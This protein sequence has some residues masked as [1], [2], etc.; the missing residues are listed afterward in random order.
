[1]IGLYILGLLV[2]FIVIIVVR[3]ILFRPK[4]QERVE[5]EKVKVNEDKIVEDMIALIQCKTVSYRDESLILHEEFTKFQEELKVRFPLVHEAC[6]LKKIGKNGLLYYL[7]GKSSDKVSVCMAH[8]DVVPADEEKWEKPP[9]S[10][11]LEDGV[12]W[13]RGTLDTKGTL[14]AVLEATEQLL[15]EGYKPENDVYFSFSGE[16]EIDGDTCA[17]IVSYFEEKGIRP[18]FVLDE[19]GAIVDNV[20]PGVE[21]D[22]ALIGVGEKGSVN[23]EFSMKSQGGH[24]STPPVHTI[25][26]KLAQAIVNIEKKPF[27]AQYTE[28]VLGMFDV[29]GR[30]SSFLYRLL[31]ANLWCFKPL[32]SLVCKISGGELNAL[33]RTTCA[34]TR[35]NGSDAFNVLP[36]EASFGLNMRVL[37]DETIESTKE[38]LQKIVGEEIDIQVI[39]GM[40]P[41]SYSDTNCEEYQMLTDVIFENWSDLIVS[42]YLMLA[43]SDSR[44][45]N[46]ISDHVYRFCAMKLSKEERGMIHGHNE[47]V[48]VET[49]LQTVRFYVRL[50]KRI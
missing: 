23:L 2:V 16:E 12:I 36:T 45:Y 22:C 42:P 14:L 44:H 18:D 6:D 28:P 29:L 13:G 20:F 50:L 35:M 8:Y 1:M 41:S 11:A 19:G 46:R 3:T 47:R 9:F 32:F 49:L 21:Q 38:R 39:N 10:G 25:A 15:G 37:G 40:N 17:D 4:K 5:C 7:K 48:P 27:K 26:G 30:H 34:V 31:F 24:A 43:C 33:V